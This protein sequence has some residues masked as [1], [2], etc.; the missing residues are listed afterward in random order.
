MLDA[1]VVLAKVAAVDRCVRRIRDA[2]GLDASRLDDLD[3]QDVFVLNV[4][5]AAQACIDLASH[6]IAA[7]EIGLADTLAANFTL[8]EREGIITADLASRMRGMVGFR[9]VAVHDYQ[10]LEPAVLRAIL[11]DHLPDFESFCTAIVALL[12]A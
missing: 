1:D 3:V 11:T 8:L 6:V 2:T 10:A 7:R 9:N 5:R 12:P 4:E